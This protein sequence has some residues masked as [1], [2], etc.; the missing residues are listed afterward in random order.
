MKWLAFTLAIVAALITLGILAV[1]ERDVVWESNQ[2]KCPYCRVDL[3]HYSVVCAH[4]DRSIDWMPHTQSC[5]WCLA[6]ADVEIFNDMFTAVGVEEGP[7]PGQLAEFPVGYFLSMDE[8]ACT[9]CSGLGQVVVDRAEVK[10]PVC[11]GGKFC[12]ACSGTRSVIH[13]DEEAHNR[14]LRRS[15]ERNSS[16]RRELVTGLPLKRGLMTDRDV[17]ALAGYA[18][19]ESIQDEHGRNVL[20]RA[21]A[22]IKRAFRALSAEQGAGKRR[23]SG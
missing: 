22:R 23:K 6:E 11:R 2:P 1:D 17:E 15:E 18:E 20:E 5:E 7:L 12:I 13:G 9:Y 16:E 21:R 8:G 14:R 10:C 3:E 4:C 19:A